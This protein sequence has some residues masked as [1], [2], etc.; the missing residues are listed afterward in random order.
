M[1]KLMNINS[2]LEKLYTENWNNLENTAKDI[3]NIAHP[4]LIKVD[5]G[6]FCKS[7]IKVIIFGQET[8][9]WYGKFPRENTP[10]SVKELMDEYHSYYYKSK[11]KGKR[12]FWNRN[13][14]KYFE[15]K[16]SQYFELKNITT[17]F[18]WNNISKIGNTG[19]GKAKKDIRGLEI[20]YFKVI[21]N[22]MKILNPDIIIFTTGHSRD[23]YIIEAFGK[24]HVEFEYPKL[25][26]GSMQ[27]SYETKKMVAKVK[28][29]NF[30]KIHAIRIEHPNRRTLSNS[31]IFNV[32]KDFWE[33]KGG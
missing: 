30:P 28:L 4:L 25:A 16:I 29:A 17:A 31:L 22:E 21:E 19:R 27:Q 9:G 15:E 1:E 26:F 14:F 12:P 24:D 3:S 20:K 23:K 6:I 2:S 5:E 13:N 18:I 33:T 7:D 10:I 32:L 8:D 11:K